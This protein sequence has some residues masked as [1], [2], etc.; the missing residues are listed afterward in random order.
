MNFNEK[1]SKHVLVELEA[2][3]KWRHEWKFVRNDR[4]L[5]WHRYQ[6]QELMQIHFLFLTSVLTTAV[7]FIVQFMMMKWF[8]YIEVL[9]INIE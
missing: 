6:Y 1:N 7:E 4:I 8:F 2:I 3:N 9:T 5:K